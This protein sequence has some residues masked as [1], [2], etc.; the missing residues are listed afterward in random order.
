[1]II[2]D[3]MPNVAPIVAV[4]EGNNNWTIMHTIV[5]AN[6]PPP[7]YFNPIFV[8]GSNFIIVLL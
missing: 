1:M 6:N 3:M 2:T 8:A 4:D 7:I 5:K